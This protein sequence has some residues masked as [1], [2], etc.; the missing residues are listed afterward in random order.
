VPVYS[1]L[2]LHF[3][4]AGPVSYRNARRPVEAARAIPAERL[5]AETDAPDQSPEPHRG[6]RCEPAFVA[7][8]VDALARARGSTA[9]HIAALTSANARHLFG[10]QR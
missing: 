8:V 9:A 3:S 6:Q 5:L 1:A 4:L 2:G 7:A 10:F